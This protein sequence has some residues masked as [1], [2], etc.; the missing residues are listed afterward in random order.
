LIDVLLLPGH[1][2]DERMWAAAIASLRAS[3]YRTI[4]PDLSGSSSIEAM[5]A[6]VLAEAPAR[7][8]LVGFS[9]G[10]IV[11]VEMAALAPDRLLGLVLIATNA[12]PDL[13][14]RS[15]ARL[16]Q[17]EAARGGGLRTLVAEELKPAYLG[18]ANRDRRDL[19]DL[20]MAMAERAGPEA[21]LRQ[22]EALRTRRERRDLLPAISAP[23]LLIS[24]AEDVLCPPSVHFEMGEAMPNATVRVIEGAG[25]MVPLEQ[26]ERFQQTLLEWLAL[27]QKE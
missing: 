20:F 17:Q 26:P 5:A 13:P 27:Q 8:F 21:F 1:L 2:C 15:A 23:A 16:L 4:V 24:G 19:L 22:S 12:H 7:F 11:A 25:H 18:A 10:G 3:G 14:E 6:E 9:L